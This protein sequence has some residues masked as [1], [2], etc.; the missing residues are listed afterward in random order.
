M[1]FI[2][3][4]E[5]IAH[6]YENG[7]AIGAFSAH[8]AETIQAILWAADEEQAPIMIQVGQ[9]VI[10]HIGL[11]AMKRMIEEFAREVTVPVCIHLDHS[12]Q[13]EQTFKAIQLQFQS[14][15]FDGSALPFAENAAITRKVVDVARAL[16][17]GT[18]GEIGKIGG[19]EDDITVAEEDAMLT[20]A[21]EAV[22][23]VEATDVD[24]LAV[25]F[26]TAHGIYK[27]TPKLAF[28][29]L[30]EIREV[31]RRPIVMHGGSDVP[32]DQ[33]RRAISLGV[34]KINV[35]TELRQAFTRGM[36]NVLESNPEEYHL[37]VS[38]GEGRNVMKQKVQEKIR[39][40]GSSG[41]AKSFFG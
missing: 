29:R 36:L 24:Y 32:D 26:G 40:F 25:S 15:M 13:I 20:T 33:V 34:A 37:A 38:L 4:R 14:V 35:D 2:S 9:R 31:V 19:T 28:E 10:H 3:G 8:N 11:E 12:R 6:A 41:K 30:E 16:G 21:E 7:Y 39:L 18:E 23:F 1:R 17:I 5:M 22:R 27:K